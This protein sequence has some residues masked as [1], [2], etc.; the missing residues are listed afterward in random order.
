MTLT[1]QEPKN[2]KIWTTSVSKVFVWTNQ[3]RPAVSPWWNWDLTKAT[4]I[5][6]TQI[7][8][9]LCY[10][11]AFSDD[12]TRFYYVTNEWNRQKWK[13]YQY[14]LWTARDVSTKGYSPTASFQF[15][16]ASASY[17]VYPSN[18][19]FKNNGSYLYIG[20]SNSGTTYI[21]WYTL[22]TPREISTASLVSSTNVPWVDWTSVYFSDDWT[23]FYYSNTKVYH[24]QVTTSRTPEVNGTEV[25]SS[26][27]S[28]WF[29]A[30]DG[31]NVYKDGGGNV[32]QYSM[33]TPFDFSTVSEVA[34]LTKPSAS[35]SSWTCFNKDGT[36]MYTARWALNT[37]NVYTY[38]IA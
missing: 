29:V 12:G 16:S 20:Y 3:V 11:L 31:S 32:V 18:F 7:S 35:Y 26:W 17:W 38:T 28:R 36:I 22:S 10:W 1:Q 13:C 34:T 9:Y 4:L 24:K 25:Y 30:P 14:N 27:L 5:K 23:D 21:D 2:I 37:P 8:A 6:T 33:S 15:W 19:I